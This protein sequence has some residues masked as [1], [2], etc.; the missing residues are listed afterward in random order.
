MF[1][2][3]YITIWITNVLFFS[4]DYWIY[5]YLSIFWI[6]SDGFK[7]IWHC[8]RRKN[9]HPNR[10]C[11]N[12]FIIHYF[13]E[14]LRV[15]FEFSL[16][17]F[18]CHFLSHLQVFILIEGKS[19]SSSL[20]LQFALTPAVG[21]VEVIAWTNLIVD[22]GHWLKVTGED[23]VE[24]HCSY[25]EVDDQR[26]LSLSF[27]KN[28]QKHR[29]NTCKGKNKNVNMIKSN[30]FFRIDFGRYIVQFIFVTALN[31]AARKYLFKSNKTVEMSNIT[32]IK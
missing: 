14:P 25:I 24:M 13:V 29:A 8:Q 30:H 12:Q 4:S 31:P 23:N 9:F 19:S 15:S 20:S 3:K 5:E 2:P 32:F 7:K 6:L 18:R 27:L 11:Q 17:S 26:F 16:S 10:Q 22:D 1:E 21:L 28:N